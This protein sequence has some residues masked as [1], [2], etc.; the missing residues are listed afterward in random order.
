MPKS[1]FWKL[2]NLVD[3]SG[4]VLYLDGPIAS[5][6][7]WGDEVTPQDFR[8]ELKKMA[9]NKLTVVINSPGGDVWAGVSIHDA[10]K[11]LDAE[12]TVKVS[13]VAASIAS[14]VA[15]AGDKI[16]MTPGSTMMIHRA[17]MLAIGSADDLEKAI[18]MLQTVEEGIVNIYAERTGK[19]VDEIK[20]LME[21]ETWMSAEKAVELGFADEVEKAEQTDLVQNVFAGNYAFSMS[22][23]KE[24]LQD[25]VQKV[26]N[27]SEDNQS[28]DVQPE[29]VEPVE[30]TAEETNTNSTEKEINEMPPIEQETKEIAQNQVLAPEN[31]AG[32]TQ[33]APTD[34][35]KTE[36]SVEDFAK[37]LATNVGK[38][39]D[40][41]KNAWREN[42]V[43][44]GLVDPSVL[45][46]PE[47]LV[48]E[49]KDAMERSLIYSRLNHTGLDSFRVMWDKQDLNLDTSRAGQHNPDWEDNGTVD[50][51]KDEQ[52]LDFDDRTLEADFIY[53]YL[54]LD[55]KTV[56]ANRSSGAL[57][58]FVMRELP[59]RIIREME[60]AAIIGDGRA[61]SSK[62]KI[63]S[64]I[65]VKSDV[66]AGNVFAGSYTPTAGMS[67][68]E[69]VARAADMLRAEGEVYLIAK[70]GFSTAAR[71]ETNSNGDLLFPVG[72]RAQDIFDVAGVIEPDWFTDATD[73]D[74]DAYLV[75][76]NSYKTVGD[77]AVESFTNFRL[78]TNENEYLQ[79]IYKGGGLSELKAAVGIAADGS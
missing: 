8:N 34:Y 32:V 43:Q 70:K 10:L 42:L 13:G 25:F 54:V 64:F 6:T 17:S 21:D 60:R 2:V 73:A 53:K 40:D 57:L 76:L 61:D 30:S 59:A 55:K 22:A 16:V 56:R 19:P 28:E 26:A 77:N 67:R 46:L 7:W 51:T 29:T 65:S 18:E 48:T 31:Q 75:V 35:L 69:A 20:Q 11:D 49:I 47:P 4:S 12:V 44:N 27:T 72:T 66:V 58:R 5:E 9:G 24:S 1:K 33:A 50:K 3:S 14:V 63:T 68:Y 78:E 52:L 79:E 15:M 45:D 36:K 38:S 71:F 74:Y 41:V 39:A 37:V 62:R 23:T